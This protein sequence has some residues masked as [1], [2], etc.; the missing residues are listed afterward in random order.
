MLMKLNEIFCK[1]KALMSFF[2]FFLSRIQ[3]ELAEI[4]LDPPP[5][6]R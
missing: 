1:N 6:C 5:N 4:T 3:K 2:F